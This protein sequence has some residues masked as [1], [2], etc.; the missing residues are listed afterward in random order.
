[1]VCREYINQNKHS[2]FKQDPVL[3]CTLPCHAEVDCLVSEAVRATSAAITYFPPQKIGNRLFADGGLEY[4]NPSHAIYE[5]Y[6]ET[7]Y[8]GHGDLKFSNI[9]IINIGTGTKTDDLLLPRSS[10]S[11][12]I[13][14]AYRMLTFL[15]RTLVEAA[16]NAEN[17]ANQ[18]KTLAWTSRSAERVIKFERFSAD[19]GVCFIKLDKYKKLQRVEDLTRAYL[20]KSEVENR[21]RLLGSEIAREYLQKRRSEPD[22][23][24]SIEVE[25][26][27]STPLPSLAPPNSTISTPP[28]APL[29]TPKSPEEGAAGRPSIND[30]ADFDAQAVHSILTL[31]AAIEP[32]SSQPVPLSSHAEHHNVAAMT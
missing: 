31:T 4:N 29:A 9:R 11:V 14:A 12:Y 17:V 32:F 21:L 13:P 8:T 1:M 19:N 16:V 25:P 28:S 18:M 23:A 3:I 7:R 10:E 22:A 26:A 30:N 6:D 24:P 20:E 5:H 2:Y 15:K 27:V